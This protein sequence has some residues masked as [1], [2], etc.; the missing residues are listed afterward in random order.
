MTQRVRKLRRIVAVQEKLHRLEEFRLA[1]LRR[2]SDDLRRDEESLVA[3]LND[4]ETFAGLFVDAMASQLKRLARESVRV[5]AAEARQSA[6]VQDA[7]LRLKRTERFT[8][9]AGTEERRTDEKQAFRELL[10]G[11]PGAP[12]DASLV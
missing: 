1:E 7:A 5:A 6:R 3:A 10:D 12:R 2:Q 9:R 4:D 11:L 8:R